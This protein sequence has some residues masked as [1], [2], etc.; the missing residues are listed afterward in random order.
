LPDLA[1]PA[2]FPWGYVRSKVYETSST[3]F[4]NLRKEIWECIEEIPE[5][6]LLDINDI[7]SIEIAELY[8]TTWWSP[9]LSY[10]DSNSEHEFSW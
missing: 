8:Q 2:Y 10:S 1:V 6:A 5:K 4:D 7:L 9:A 3:N